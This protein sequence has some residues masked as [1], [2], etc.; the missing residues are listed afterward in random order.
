VATAV[1]DRLLQENTT[2]PLKTRHDVV[3]WVRRDELMG[4]EARGADVLTELRSGRREA[5]DTLI[6]T[7]YRLLAA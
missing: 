4:S 5:L 2:E 1:C 7:L 3:P 6:V